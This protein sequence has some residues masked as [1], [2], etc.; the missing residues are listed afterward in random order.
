MEISRTSE[1]ACPGGHLCELALAATRVELSNFSIEQ[2]GVSHFGVR[3][4]RELTVARFDC[5]A[6]VR[7]LVA[8]TRDSLTAEQKRRLLSNRWDLFL[9]LLSAT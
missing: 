1:V 4:R 2:D 3:H 5:T 9:L 6:S 8:T 7:C